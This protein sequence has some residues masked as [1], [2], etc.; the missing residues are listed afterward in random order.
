MDVAKQMPI[1]EAFLQAGRKGDRDQRHQPEGTEEGPDPDRAEVPL[2]T[3]DNDADPK[4]AACCYIGVDNMEAGRAVGRLV[5]KALPE[6]RNDRACSSAATDS[7]NGKARTQGVLEELARVRPDGAAA[8][9]TFNG[10]GR[11]REDVRQVFPRRWAAQDRR[12]PG[13]EPANS[14]RTRCSAGSKAYPMCA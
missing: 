14:I 9:R 1:V 3:M 6:W 2:I 12:R 7:A 4:P 11:W 5:K 8:T 13:E 10:H